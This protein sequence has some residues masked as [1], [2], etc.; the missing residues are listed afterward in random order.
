MNTNRRGFLKGTMSMG[1]TMA[2]GGGMVGG[3]VSGRG[4]EEE[5]DLVVYG[6]TSG[7]VAAAVQ[8]ARMGMRVVLLEPS[9]HLGGLTT[10]GLGRTD[11]GRAEAVGGVALEFYRRLRRHYEDP[12]V[13]VREAP[14]LPAGRDAAWDFEPHAAAAVYRAMLAEAGVPVVMGERLRAGSRGVLKRGRDIAGI[15]TGGG[16][17]Y[18]ARFF[19]DATYEGDL[20]AAAGVSYRVGREANREF[21]ETLNGVQ[22]VRTHNHIF[23][24]FVDPYVVPGNRG[25]GLLPGVHGGDAGVEGEGDDRVQAYCFRMCLTDDPG[26]RVPFERPEGYEELV[27]ELLF[28]NF[29][30]GET[31]V[32]W[33]PG[34]MPNRK[35]DTNNRWGFSTNQV[36][37][38]A[39]YPDG[40]E[41]V[42]ESIV[43]EQEHYQ[44]GL[45][46]ALAHHPRV[47][48][49][50]R[51]EVGRWGYAADEFVDH[52]NWPPQIY[53]R[54]ARRMRGEY[55]VTEHDC[56]RVRVAG[57][58]VGLG[59]Y[60]MDSHNVQRYVT[61]MG[62]VQ[63]EGNIEVNPGGPY[64]I[65]Y[66]A[67][68][69]RRAECGNLLV[70]CAV[71][72]SHIAYGSIR[73]EPVFMILGQSAATAAALALGDGVPLH[74]L[75]HGRLRE[76]LVRDGQRLEI[77][78]ERFPAKPAPAGW[79]RRRERHETEPEVPVSCE[80]TA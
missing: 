61:A 69:P 39:A 55:V 30:A 66:R 33:L 19:V 16:R 27:Y 73:M 4:G 65:P 38:S 74:D 56:R 47:P 20:M 12:S 26:N 21:G 68:L 72:A 10:S 60:S 67:L 34:R 41:G 76:R 18:A 43:R 53:V 22:K 17:R 25:S 44:R 63:N 42:R 24:G 71:S 23:P 51:A 13:W 48:P 9:K 64:A 11:A 37:A 57:D 46:W 5:W 36:G 40:S 6:G 14:N 58:A 7:G 79:P 50:V 52:R 62:C 70:C 28:R 1:L 78:L 45:M 59:S 54:E 80:A 32:P 35:T 8:A 31:R 3:C 75:P 2:M 49:H 15:E 29:E 77:D